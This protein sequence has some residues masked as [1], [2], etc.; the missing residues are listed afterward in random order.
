M[1]KNQEAPRMFAEIGALIQPSHLGQVIWGM[2]KP[3]IGMIRWSL[4]N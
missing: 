3:E 2:S 4:S 1:S